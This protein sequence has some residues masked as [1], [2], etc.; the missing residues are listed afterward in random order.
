MEFERIVRLLIRKKRLGQL[1]WERLEF[2]F[3]TI[4]NEFLSFYFSSWWTGAKHTA[5]WKKKLKRRLKSLQNKIPN[6]PIRVGLRVRPTLMGAVQSFSSKLP[7][8][9]FSVDLRPKRRLDGCWRLGTTCSTRW[10]LSRSS[11]HFPRVRVLFWP[12]EAPHGFS[13]K[14]VE[15]IKI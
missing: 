14:N 15:E 4:S 11:L 8:E 2:Y 9:P 12:N 1:L 10:G 3:A 7:S 5:V 6:S 13:V